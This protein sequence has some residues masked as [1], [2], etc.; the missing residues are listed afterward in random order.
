L[1][2]VPLR[3]TIKSQVTVVPPLQQAAVAPHSTV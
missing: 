1:S 3:P 2:F